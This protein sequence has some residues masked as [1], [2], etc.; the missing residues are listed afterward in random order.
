MLCLKF[1]KIVNMIVWLIWSITQYAIA[2]MWVLFCVYVYVPSTGVTLHCVVTYTKR[3]FLVVK[4]IDCR[5][6]EAWQDTD[7][8]LIE[9]KHQSHLAVRSSPVDDTLLY[10]PISSS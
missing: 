10:V 3:L 4:E 9:K 1:D 6:K 8:A 2:I 5:E 7:N